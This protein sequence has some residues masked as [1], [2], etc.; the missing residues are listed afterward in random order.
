M[1]AKLQ[2]L[3]DYFFSQRLLPLY[4]LPLLADEVFQLVI[5][6]EAKS[7]FTRSR[8]QI[9]VR[10]ST[11]EEQMVGLLAFLGPLATVCSKIGEWLADPVKNQ[12]GY[13]FN[14]TTNIGK[15]RDGVEDLENR[16]ASVQ[17]SVDAAM[18][19]LEVIKPDVLAWMNGV[20]DLKKEADKVLQA[21][22]SLIQKWLWCFG[23][24]FLNIKSR[25]SRSRKAVKMMEVVI[26]LQE[27]YK[28]TNVSDP[29]VPVEITDFKH[30]SYSEGFVSRVSI[31]N[32]IMESFK[33]DDV[34]VIGVMI[35]PLRIC[36]D[37]D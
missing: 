5:Y 35:F 36:Y 37:S 31:R 34:H 6:P 3:K 17:N 21:S 27:K 20:D 15:L 28:F 25:Y 4:G 8:I 24:R 12:Y 18:R 13:L 30:L 10:F 33:D 22:T 2:Y 16:R 1:S 26:Q 32:E 23:G 7:R 29:P 11:K 19:N 14:Y 9:Y